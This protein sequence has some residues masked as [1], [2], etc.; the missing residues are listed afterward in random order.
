MLG[1]YPGYGQQRWRSMWDKSAPGDLRKTHSQANQF[2]PFRLTEFCLSDISDH[3]LKL[4]FV[5]GVL[6]LALYTCLP[7][8]SLCV[9]PVGGRGE[10]MLSE[11]SITLLTSQSLG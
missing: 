11:F 2:M 9:E 4:E 8:L 3:V 7:P 10:K 5:G 1:L 6:H